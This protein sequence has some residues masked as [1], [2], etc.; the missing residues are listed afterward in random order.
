VSDLVEGGRVRA[1]P[2]PDETGAA[3][4]G[5]RLEAI[6]RRFA[7]AIHRRCRAILAD[8]DEALDA[9]HDIF[10]ILTKKL[11]TFRG[12]AELMTWIYR[13]STNHCLNRLRATRARKRMI[14]ARAEVAQPA[15]DVS[16]ELERRDLLHALLAELGADDVQLLVHYYHDEMTQPEIA[17]VLGVSERTVRARLR[18]L[19]M[20]AQEQLR[21]LERV[22]ERGR[23]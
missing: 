14:D 1:V 13:I 11:D 2:W 22:E 19:E 7:P 20:R 21:L 6:Y 8:E 16:V 3:A 12:D 9:L 23:R 4:G 18:K 15:P 5:D 17:Q 10:L